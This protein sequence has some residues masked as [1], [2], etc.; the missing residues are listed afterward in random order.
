MTV[1]ILI[2]GLGSIGQRHFRNLKNIN[3][4]INF[5]AYREKKTSPLLSPNNEVLKNEFCLDENN[6][7][8]VLDLLDIKSLQIDA[9]LICNPN[10]MH[11]KFAFWALENDL[12]VFIEKPVSDKLYDF[13]KLIKHDSNNKVWVG[14]QFRFHPLLKKLKKILEKKQLGNIISSSFINGEYLPDWHK[15]ENYEKSYAA[16]KNLGGGCI[17]TLIHEIDYATWLLGKP[18]NVYAIG[19]TLSDLKT[20]VEDSVQLLCAINHNNKNIPLSISLNYLQFPSKKYF[21]II[22][23]KGSVECDLIHGRMKIS[24]I[25]NKKE[26]V[27]ELD[28]FDRNEMFISE[29]TEFLKFIENKNSIHISL[30]DALTSALIAE[31][32]LKSI[33]SGKPQTLN[34]DQ[35]E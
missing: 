6:I 18:K 1:N 19:G 14:L 9:V 20:D 35:H 33:Q 11:F 28:D 22:G 26:K 23:D 10:S 34:W 21:Y 25:K 17:V 4:N 29:M 15:Y 2:I 5:F 7:T 8:E 3:N 27:I 31:Q 32:S 24:N 12:Y 13:K 30:K 16:K